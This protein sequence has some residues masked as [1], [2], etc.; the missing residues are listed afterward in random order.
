MVGEGFAKGLL[1]LS[2]LLLARLLDPAEYGE[3]G[4]VRSTSSILATLGGMGLGLTANRFVAA[5]LGSDRH[6]CGEVIGSSYLLALTAS[7]VLGGAL[8]LGAPWVASRLLEHP[9]AVGSLRFACLLLVLSAVNGAQVGMLQGLAAFKALAICSFFQAM[10]GLASMVGG[11]LLLGLDGALIG[12]LVHGAVGVL[13]CHVAISPVLRKHEIVIGWRVSPRMRSILLRFSMPLVL[14]F[15]LVAPMRWFGETQ[16]VRTAGFE[17]LGFFHAAMVIVS[18]IIVVASTLNAPLITASA[19]LATS[20]Q[21]SRLTYANLYG[22]WYVFVALA[23]PLLAFP[24]LIVMAFGPAFGSE[25]FLA[26]CVVLISYAGFLLLNQ[27]IGRLITLHGSMWYGLVTNAVEG[28]CLVLGIF[29]LMHH[30]VVGVSIAY[31]LSM[32]AR[33]LVSIP[34]LVRTGIAPVQIFFDK[35]FLGTLALCSALVILRI[36]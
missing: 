1:L 4:L 16:I 13:A 24:G 26:T 10:A 25:R 29:G 31:V 2:M 34:Y 32:L 33:I 20:S 21:A 23:L 5:H 9:D 35:Y 19:G 7:L 22:S 8:Y 36:P 27:G 28:L 6:F 14:M 11:A 17:E 18:G 12:L 3:L 30:G 15:L